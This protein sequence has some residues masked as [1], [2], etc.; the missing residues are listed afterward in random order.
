MLLLILIWIWK[1]I[2][3]YF[4]QLTTKDVAPAPDGH[5]AQAPQGHPAPNDLLLALGEYK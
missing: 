3:A 5:S 2:L 4:L 1:W